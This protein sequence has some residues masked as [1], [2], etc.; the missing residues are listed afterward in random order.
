MMD[1]SEMETMNMESD[2][3]S[4]GDAVSGRG[5]QSASRDDD[6]LYIPERRPSLDLGQ[7]PMDTNHWFFMDR[8]QS[9]AQSY[10]SMTSDGFVEMYDDIESPTRIQLA[11][12]DSYSSCYSWDSDDCEKRILKVKIKEETV[13]EHPDTPEEIQDSNEFNHPSVTVKFTFEAISNTLG[14]LS[15]R[16]LTKFK[17]MLCTRY[18]RSFHADVQYMDMVNLV[19]RLLECYSLASLNITVAILEEMGQ[20]KMAA[21]LRNVCVRNEVHYDLCET[22]KREYGEMC[23]NMDGREERRPFD[24]IYANLY[25][26][27]TC[28]N[29]PNIEHEVMTI[30][31]LDSN[32]E[33]GKQLSTEDIFTTKTIEWSSKK[34]MLMTGV[35]GSGKSM[36]VRRLILDWAKG[37]SHHDVSFVFPLSLKELKKFEGFTISLLEIIQTLYPETKKLKDGDFRC[38][39]C[40]IMFI[41]DGIDEYNEVLDFY[42]TTLLSDPTSPATLNIIVVNLLRGRLVHHGLLLVTSRPQVQSCIPWD[43]HYDE[44]EV[45]GFCDPYKDEY[46]YRRFKDPNQAAQVVAYI[47]SFT[48]L[49]I[50]CHLPLFCSLI[51]DECDRVFRKQGT[52]TELPR[53]ITYMYTKLMLELAQRRRG[54]ECSSHKKRDLL[55]NL[56]KMALELLEQQK[57]KV[58]IYDWKNTEMEEEAVNNSGLCMEYLTRPLILFDEKMLSF[59][60]PTVQEYMAALYAFLSFTNDGKNIFEE[61]LKGKGKF[62]GIFKVPKVTDLYKGAVDRSLSCADGKLD[63]FL[64]FL[65]GMA[66]R[67]NL[68]LLQPFLTS[69][70]HQLVVEDVATHIGKRMRENRFPGRNDN[71]QC[72]LAELGV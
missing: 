70:A 62:R 7:S 72:C 33:P 4:I 42:N 59:I 23:V 22:L 56:G 11:R 50:M 21:D 43:T 9:P 55:M 37:Q 10:K 28:D 32:Q 14:K 44:M 69:S 60:H 35:A 40:K 48:T 6:E 53:S 65:C 54:P 13:S 61:Q 18:P 17:T 1:L 45:R 15:E 38:E 30:E 20:K 24:D 67:T 66:C 31:K 68:E 16:A 46:F 49:R 64:R 36:A 58:A 27:S 41:L 47:N 63:I 71:L 12:T 3:S 52:R 25:I 34:L 5:Q 39:D 26:S 57:F 8:A 2:S 19:D 51:A 29:G